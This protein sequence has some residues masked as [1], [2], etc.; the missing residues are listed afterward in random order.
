MGRA[1]KVALWLVI[2]LIALFVAAT[3]AFRVFFDPNDFRADIE[4][5]VYESTG[6]ELAIEGEVS[7][8]IFPWLAVEVG[9]TRLGNAPGFGDDAF[10]EFERAELSVRLLPLLF[11]SE[12]KIGTAEI[13]GL[14]LDLR[15]DAQGRSNWSDLLEGGAAA[16]ADEPANPGEQVARER[17]SEATLEI[18]GVAIRDASISYSDESNGDRYALT[19]VNLGLGRIS[20]D[21]DAIPIDGGLAFDVQ[22]AGYT[23]TIEL[24]TSVSFDGDTGAVSFG[25]SS[26]EGV[27]AG[28]AAEPTQMSFGTAGVE[29]DTAAQ[30]VAMQPLELSVLGVD[31]SAEAEPFSY[32][33][34]ITPV[35]AIR[36]AAFSPRT[37]MQML[38]V[39]APETADPSAL[40]SVMLSA[41]ANVGEEAVRLTGLSI[42]LDD[43][44][45]TGLMTMPFT[46][47]GRF[48]A[49]LDGDAI[50]LNRYMAPA[51]DEGAADAG[52]TPPLE[53][54]AELLE[55]LNVK[56]ELTLDSVLLGALQLDD[57]SV[58]VDAANG[59]TRIYPI[60]AQLFGGGYKGDIRIDVSGS[61]P[62]LAVNETVQ[63]ID[64]ARLAKAM[65]E[66]D[67]ITGSLAGN[68]RLG[69][70][71]H[72]MA[73]V[74]QTLAGTMSFELR[75]GT[76][77]GVDLWYELRRARAALKQ[78]EP[79][80]SRS[81]R[82]A[83]DSRRVTATGVVRRTA[84]CATTI[85]RPSCRSCSS[86][87]VATSTS[88]WAR[89]TTACAR[90]C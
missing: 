52:A 11:G 12:V 46:S 74:Q 8:Q 60:A 86:R 84:S 75:D 53:I 58:T 9:R 62:S 85:S 90:V 76:Y 42:K 66:Q 81:C 39:E 55:P 20:Q 64:L 15:V 37:L 49:K 43:T 48:I 71:G 73:E 34:A 3:V 23:G 29:V 87:A 51:G 30:T 36:V 5:A 4:R 88:R 50:D 54:P 61:V 13:E 33:G 25:S 28:V 31:I 83:R 45:F 69:G 7:L 65:F 59:R 24:D 47:S 67:N 35:A 44:S 70:R 82:R 21:G 32:A 18:S 17:A 27:V 26:L 41:K 63:D 6:R 78:E 89:S 38:G 19:D 68:F 14:Q 10:A 2:A 22:P 56:G 57:V 16:D 77:E 79:P 1:S 40:T 72:N 80:R